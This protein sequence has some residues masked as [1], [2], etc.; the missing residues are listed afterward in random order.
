MLIVDCFSKYL[1][2]W[3]HYTKMA[4]DCRDALKELYDKESNRPKKL[5]CDC[6]GE[7]KAQVIAYLESIG[8][9]CAF[10]ILL[11]IKYI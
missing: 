6:G 5:Q 9:K 7:F 2:A 4:V 8:I 1:W 11:L 3:I 10:P